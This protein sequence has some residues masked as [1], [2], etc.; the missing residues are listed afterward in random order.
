[1]RALLSF[2]LF[3][4]ACS[5]SSPGPDTGLPDA[6][7]ADVP[8]VDAWTPPD[9]GPV[10]SDTLTFGPDPLPVGAERTV[11]IVLDAGNDVARQVRAIRT[12]LPEGSHHMIVYQ[13]FEAVSTTPTPCFPF[14][15]GGSAIFIAETVDAYLRYPPEAALAFRPHQHIKIEVHEVN[16]LAMPLDIT[17]SVTFEY[18]PI[19]APTASPVQFLF[20][21]DMSLLLPARSTS[22]E[23]SFHFVPDGANVFGLTSHTHSLGVR[24]TIHRGRSE[25]DYSDLLH[26]SL[27]W[28][29]PRLDVFD[30]ALTFAPGEG[31]RLSCEF[32]NTTS[33]NV[34]FGLDFADEMCFLWAYYY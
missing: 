24:A 4:G 32:D 34:S 17:A 10:D 9:A 12:H 27:D 11:C 25:T 13:T 26:E 18:D 30:P 33:S 21:G 1:M 19:G 7:G 8:G 5:T 6:P 15:D 22:T 16:Y 14:A 3:L 28:A 23:T 29:N 31:L 2:V 20:T